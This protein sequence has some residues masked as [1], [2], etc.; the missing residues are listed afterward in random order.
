M[1]PIGIIPVGP[2][3]PAQT[4]AFL[5]RCVDRDTYDGLRQRRVD[6]LRPVLA[7]CAGEPFPDAGITRLVDV[8][9]DTHSGSYRASTE[10]NAKL[11]DAETKAIDTKLLTDTLLDAA[12]A[13]FVDMVDAE[14][15][16]NGDGLVLKGALLLARGLQPVEITRANEPL[17][18][19]RQELLEAF[20]L[21]LLQSR[22]RRGPLLSTNDSMDFVDAMLQAIR[23]HRA[24]W[25]G[26]VSG[27][28]TFRDLNLEWVQ[29][30]HADTYDVHDAV[31]YDARKRGGTGG[32]AY[33][34]FGNRLLVAYG[35]SPQYGHYYLHTPPQ[36]A[37]VLLE[38]RAVIEADLVAIVAD[39][40]GNEPSLSG[41]RAERLYVKR[42]NDASYR[43]ATRRVLLAWQSA[44]FTPE[45]P[46]PRAYGRGRSPGSSGPSH[47][48]RAAPPQ[49]DV[50]PMSVVR[51]EAA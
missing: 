39:V 34:T 10:R 47:T 23:R 50:G 14:D 44:L 17:N 8:F 21:R 24:V 49:A 37:G 4:E 9:G 40:E 26:R 29:P 27:Y 48:G 45:G 3:T 13:T 2:M 32:F 36:H 19:D 12:T 6:A 43:F 1:P 46:D 28:Q 42:G 18:S 5:E 16:P 25:I 51:K 22:R 38:A 35:P 31:Q 30:A 33:A 41:F 15:W 20:I 7:Y 11:A